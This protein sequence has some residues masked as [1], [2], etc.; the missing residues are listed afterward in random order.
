MT[1]LE[2][3]IINPKEFHPPSS[4]KTFKDAINPEGAINASVDLRYG[5]PFARDGLVAIRDTMET[6]P[7][8]AEIELL[9]LARLQGTSDV[10]STQEK[11]GKMMHERLHRYATNA[12]G[13]RIVSNQAETLDAVLVEWNLVSSLEQAKTVDD[14]I[15]YFQGDSTQL[16]V[17]EVAHLCRVQQNKTFLNREFTNNSGERKTIRDSVYAAMEYLDQETALTGFLEYYQPF[18]SSHRFA[19]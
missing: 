19:G 11:P 9:Y 5:H 2:G 13:K 1:E 7:E 18:P 16:Y 17:T 10:N 12:A 4:L 15:V 8:V 3:S 14:L 6:F